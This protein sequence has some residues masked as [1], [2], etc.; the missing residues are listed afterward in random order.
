[1]NASASTT[2]GI[3]TVTTPT[4]REIHVERVFDAPRDR[5]REAMTNPDLLAQWWGRGNRVDVERFEA[6]RVSRR[7]EHAA[8]HCRPV[9]THGTLAS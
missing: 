6:E 8:R 9:I 5:V 2:A 1:M 4:D 3:S 7:I